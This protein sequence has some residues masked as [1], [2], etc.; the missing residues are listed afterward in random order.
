MVAMRKLWWWIGIIWTTGACELLLVD[1][2]VPVAVLVALL[3]DGVVL[4]PDLAG[5]LDVEGYGWASILLVGVAYA[6]H[7]A[8][9]C[10]FLLLFLG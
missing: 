10:S 5:N 4:V 8:L 1:V 3:Q 6:G 9:I 2:V 7:P